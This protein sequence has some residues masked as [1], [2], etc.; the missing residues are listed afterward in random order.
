MLHGM[1]HVARHVARRHAIKL[2]PI[3][4]GYTLPDSLGVSLDD[5]VWASWPQVAGRLPRH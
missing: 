5:W 4:H 2:V 3:D 1:L